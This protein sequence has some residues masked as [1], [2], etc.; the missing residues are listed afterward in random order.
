MALSIFEQAQIDHR[1]LEQRV[2]AIVRAQAERYAE[3]DRVSYAIYTDKSYTPKM[4]GEGQE[5]D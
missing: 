4:V 3:R 2:D 1:E 5:W